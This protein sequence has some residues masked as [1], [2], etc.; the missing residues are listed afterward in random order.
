MYEYNSVI[1][2]LISDIE[3]LLPYNQTA[4]IDT[5]VRRDAITGIPELQRSP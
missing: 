3:S 5:S 4:M 1:T 2:D